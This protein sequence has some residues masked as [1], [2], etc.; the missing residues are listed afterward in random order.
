MSV[1]PTD[2]SG[3]VDS[4]VDFTFQHVAHKHGKEPT[5]TAINYGNTDREFE[6]EAAGGLQHNELAELRTLH[7]MVS[8][9][10]SGVG[11]DNTGAGGFECEGGIGVNVT[12]DEWARQGNPG[13]LYDLDDDGTDESN[14]VFGTDVEEAI[15]DTWGFGAMPQFKD[16]VNTSAGGGSAQNVEHFV[17][18]TEHYGTG[19]YVGPNDDMVSRVELDWVNSTHA[20]EAM[21]HYVLGWVVYE[22]DQQPHLAP[23]NR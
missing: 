18:F 5:A 23:P 3:E 22:T 11:G 16:G 19:P 14:I 13:A 12:E 17:D 7:R 6:F 8:L 2:R 1:N 20:M 15:F 10:T 4:F 21:A 9:H